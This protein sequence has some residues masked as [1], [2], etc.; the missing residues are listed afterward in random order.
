MHALHSARTA[1][2]SAAPTMQ[3]KLVGLV[4]SWLSSIDSSVCF[5]IIKSFV[6]PLSTA[7]CVLLQHHEDSITVWLVL[8]KT[9]D[10]VVIEYFSF[11]KTKGH[12]PQFATIFMSSDPS[13]TPKQAALLATPPTECSMRLYRRS[14]CW[15]KC[16]AFAKEVNL[17]K[18]LLGSRFPH[19]RALADSSR[20]CG[21]IVNQDA[22]P[23]PPR[24]Y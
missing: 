3:T 14:L 17:Q 4:G 20:K 11:A 21:N 19:G 22:F 5:I 15:Y 9:I 2:C 6:G 1:P 12:M 10:K 16:P 7:C 23:I 18:L 13:T 8:D 24:K